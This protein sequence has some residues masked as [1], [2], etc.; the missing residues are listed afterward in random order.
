MPSPSLVN[1]SIPGVVAWL[2]M[3][4]PLIPA[5][6]ADVSLSIVTVTFAL[7][8]TVSSFAGGPSPGEPPPASSS[9]VAAVDQLPVATA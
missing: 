7:I 5:A 8:T 4:R 6:K 9:Q 1:A 3:V 2:V